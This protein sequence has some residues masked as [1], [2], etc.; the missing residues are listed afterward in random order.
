M[1]PVLVWCVG[2]RVWRRCVCAANGLGEQ[3][4]FDVRGCKTLLVSSLFDVIVITTIGC[5]LMRFA[6]E[7]KVENRNAKDQG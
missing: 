6:M 4:G 2:W 3:G 1:L 5:R 7:S